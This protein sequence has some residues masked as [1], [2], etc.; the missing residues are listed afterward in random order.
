MLERI[1]GGKLDKFY[2]QICLLEQPY[3]RDDK[4]TIQ[5][6]VQEVAARTGENILV[7]RFSRFRLG[8]D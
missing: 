4:R 2:A 3:I 7:R 5:Q 8:A 6:V 1:V